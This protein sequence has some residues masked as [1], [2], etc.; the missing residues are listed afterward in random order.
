MIN[1]VWIIMFV[2]FIFIA[3]LFIILLNGLLGKILDAKEST[4]GKNYSFM[5]FTFTGWFN[6]KTK[7][8]KFLFKVSQLLLSA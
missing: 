3:D 2:I 6:D 7:K 8:P 4:R 5:D 1:L